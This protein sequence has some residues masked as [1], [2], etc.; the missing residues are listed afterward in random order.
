MS[1]IKKINIRGKIY[2]LEASTQAYK[3][4]YDN[5]T[6][7]VLTSNTVQTAIDEVANKINT[8]AMSYVG[9]IIH[10]TTLDT[11]EKVIAFYGGTTWEKMEGVFLLGASDTYAAGS[12]GGEATHTLTVNEMP[13]HS[14][15]Y[16]KTSS[17]S[18]AGSYGTGESAPF[19]NS[20]ATVTTTA[21]GGGAAHNNMPPYKAVYIWERTA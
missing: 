17:A 19:Y 18:G 15:S 11:M 4:Y 6:A 5:S 12:T 13:S 10:S 1:S 16:V 2:S 7:G 8:L 14:H 21:A 9:M 3:V 20:T